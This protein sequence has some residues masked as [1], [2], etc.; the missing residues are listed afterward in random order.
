MSVRLVVLDF[1]GTFTDSTAEG[2]PF[3]RYF[4]S[5]LSGLLYQDI[6]AEWAE[7]KRQLFEH[8]H[9]HG[10][11]YGTKV[12]APA[13]ADPYLMATCIANRM[14]SRRE[15]PRHPAERGELVQKLFAD[16]YPHSAVAFK[17]EARE[18]L[19]A[20][21]EGDVPVFV[22]TNSTTG[23]V[24][25]KIDQ[26]GLK[27]REK[28]QVFGDA[29]KFSVV[30]PEPMDARFAALPETRQMPGVAERPLYLRRG[31]YYKVL[32]GIWEATGT[33]PEETLVCG[34]IFELDLAMPAALG[35][36]VHLVTR[37]TTLPYER[38]AL[39]DLGP[40]GAVSDS[41]RDLLPRVR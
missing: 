12:V 32:R 7:E 20:L 29:Q 24:K 11:L 15:W 5:L 25:L 17:P 9:L 1:D 34:D 39:A 38:A 19:D 13:V 3:E 30:D 14:L 40:R 31:H 4:R 16:S 36:S 22:V 6:D 2:V 21:L 28:L 23:H 8:P 10:W 18:V 27:R 26:L 41:L 35:A 33:R 37:P